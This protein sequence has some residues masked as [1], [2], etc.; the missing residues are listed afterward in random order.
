[1]K[2]TPKLVRLLQERKSEAET[3]LKATQVRTTFE[4]FVE[5][6]AVVSVKANEEYCFVFKIRWNRE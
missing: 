4:T 1:M 3:F 5:A 2:K 6:K